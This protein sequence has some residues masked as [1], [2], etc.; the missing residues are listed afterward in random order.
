MRTCSSR[1][2]ARARPSTR[3]RRRRQRAVLAGAGCLPSVR[4]RDQ[5]G[6]G[7]VGRQGRG[8]TAPAAQ[9]LARRSP[10]ADEIASQVRV[11]VGP[12]AR[13]S[14]VAWIAW[15]DEVCGELRNDSSRGI[16]VLPTA[17]RCTWLLAAVEAL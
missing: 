7:R 15:A 8:R 6:R 14:A 3:S 13:G 16:L 11:D 5:P 1:P 17:L 12:V 4:V 2:E 9:D 10:A